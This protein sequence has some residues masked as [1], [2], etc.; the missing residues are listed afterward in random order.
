MDVVRTSL[1]KIQGAITIDSTLGKEQPSLF[2]CLLTPQ[3]LC[4]VSDKARI[5]FPMDGVEQMIDVPVK[6]VI[7]E[8]WAICGVVPC[9]HSDPEGTPNLQ[10]LTQPQQRLWRQLGGRHDFIVVL[11]SAGT[12]IGIQ[13]DQV[14]GE[15]EIVIKQFEGPA[16]KPV[17]V[18][19]ATILGMVG[20]CPLLTMLIDL[21]MGRLQKKQ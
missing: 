8:S 1:G 4:C 7:T 15:Q 5:A 10:S 6:N 13:V 18:A 14:L 21:S 19:G 2:A 17:G 3:A 16:P 20:S 9:C 11:R 12:F